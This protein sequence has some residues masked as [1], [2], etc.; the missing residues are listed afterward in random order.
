MGEVI[1]LR[2]RKWA[3]KLAVLLGRPDGPEALEDRTLKAIVDNNSDDEIA[4]MLSLPLPRPGP[5]PGSP[6]EPPKGH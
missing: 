2:M 6:P 4:D 1:D 3:V 5:R